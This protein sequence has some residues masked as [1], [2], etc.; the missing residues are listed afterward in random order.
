MNQWSVDLVFFFFFTLVGEKA[1][2]IL[3][4]FCPQNRFHV[5][6]FMMSLMRWWRRRQEHSN[7]SSWR[8]LMRRTSVRPPDPSF[9]AP[10]R[11]LRDLTFVIVCR[12][13]TCLLMMRMEK[14]SS[15]RPPPAPWPGFL[16]CPQNKVALLYCTVNTQNALQ[17]GE[18]SGAHPGKRPYK[19]NDM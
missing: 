15:T 3:G 16:H 4:S 17:R 13:H 2:D 12:Q 19:S 9:P 1:A 5:Q 11:P 6:H 18:G 7:P 14:G 8:S 10:R